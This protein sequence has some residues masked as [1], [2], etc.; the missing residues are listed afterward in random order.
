MALHLYSVQDVEPGQPVRAQ[1]AATMGSIKQ[2]S[3]KMKGKV[4][5]IETKFDGIRCPSH[6]HTRQTGSHC[7]SVYPVLPA[8]SLLA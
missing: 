4:F 7:C 6:L 3:Q 8:T 1:L 5:V 2:I